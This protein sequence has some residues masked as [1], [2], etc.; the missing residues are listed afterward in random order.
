[1][2]HAYKKMTQIICIIILALLY[3]IQN[4][5]AQTTE[6]FESFTAGV[7]S[8]ISIGITF[9]LIPTG[10][11]I[12]D[13]LTGY[14]YLSSNKF[15]DNFGASATTCQLK[16]ASN[17]TFNIKSLYLYPSTYAT[18]DYNQTSGVD[19]TFTGIL[20]GTTKF[21]YTPPSA[22][23]AS[24]SYLNTTNRGFSLVNFATPSYDNIQI[25]E[26]VITL[27]GT[28]VYFAIDNFTFT[29][30]GLLPIELTSFTFSVLNNGIINLNWQTATEVNNYGFEV[31]RTSLH[32]IN[33]EKIGF[34][35]GNGN[36]NSPKNYSFTDKP[37]G[38]SEFKYRLKQIDFDGQY[39]YS[40][41]VVVKLETP[42]NFS[43]KQNFPNPFNPTTK[44]E[45]SIPLD[46]YVE[47]KIYNSLGA[48]V[49][50]LLNEN[51]LA[52]RYSVEF[53]AG[54]LSSGVYFYKIVSGNYMDIK[55]LIL[56]K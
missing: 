26:L 36:S 25:D 39:E 40:P 18:G 6:T 51:R 50:T 56:L 28:T 12:V 35:Q 17:A 24:A 8:F 41:E 45:F 22:D 11:F 7:S 53:N 33:W 55:K 14:G 30:A 13:E 46:N 1:M 44:I 2:I 37:I 15:L 31:E 3:S 29:D 10:Q 52:G 43:L 5:V 54:N 48:E 49:A 4:I 21:T 19:V 38:G 9:N 20:A 32:K 47:I 42:A 23:F 16:S 34:V 27:G